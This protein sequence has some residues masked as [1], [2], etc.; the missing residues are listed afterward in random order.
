MGSKGALVCDS[1]N[2]VI[3]LVSGDFSSATVTSTTIFGAARV[4]GS[5][6]EANLNTPMGIA[7]LADNETVF[8]CD[9]GN[10]VVKM[11]NVRKN[12]K[13][14]TVVGNGSEGFQD[15]PSHSSQFNSPVAVAV[16]KSQQKLFISDRNNHTIRE[17]D[18]SS[19]QSETTSSSPNA[20]PPFHVTTLC[21]KP[22]MRGCQDGIGENAS[23]H[24]P[25]GIACS[26][27]NENILFVCD[28][29]NHII[30][31]VDVVT[32]HVVTYAGVATKRGFVDGDASQALFDFPRGICCDEDDNLYICDYFS[33]AIRKVQT[34]RKVTTVTG[35]PNKQGRID[36]C[37][38]EASLMRPNSIAIDFQN[39]NLI[40]TQLNCLRQVALPLSFYHSQLKNLFRLQRLLGRQCEDD[41][42]KRLLLNLICIQVANT[43][44]HSEC[45]SDP[46]NITISQ[47]NKIISFARSKT[48]LSL[49]QQCRNKNFIATV[50][51]SPTQKN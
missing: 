38:S 21:G 25:T 48:S 9:N 31:K 13:L 30:R 46:L 3:R 20:V 45:G 18:I 32:K 27:M 4:Q 6:E 19:L 2:H 49:V 24:S 5:W 43:Q 12:G 17:I 15:G 14:V 41:F 37:K 47:R 36:G 33:C 35:N 23:F 1:N 8:I 50:L 40:F 29:G 7:V 34:N 28:Y 16:H 22:R 11:F 42:I 39:G 26:L 51:N 10:N 44:H